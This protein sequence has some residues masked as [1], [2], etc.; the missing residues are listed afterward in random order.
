MY[1][2]R[3]AKKNWDDIL[4][5]QDILAKAITLRLKAG[6]NFLQID[7]GRQMNIERKNRICQGCSKNIEDEE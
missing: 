4:D 3:K 7:K 6:V 5:E 1:N 2:I